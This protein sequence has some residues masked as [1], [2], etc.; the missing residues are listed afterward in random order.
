MSAAEGTHKE[1]DVPLHRGASASLLY[2]RYRPKAG[3]LAG[4][5]GRNAVVG[6]AP[7]GLAGNNGRNAVVGAT[8]GDLAGNN[9]RNAVV[10]AAP[11]S[12]TYL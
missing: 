7:G 11:C 3:R 9:G 10:R 8:P 12:S 5:N 1:A 2:G 4:N 6:A